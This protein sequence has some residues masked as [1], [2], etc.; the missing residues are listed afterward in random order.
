DPKTATDPLDFVPKGY[1]VA[2]TIEGDLNKDGQVDTVLLIKGTDPRNVV[3]DAN[4]QGVDRNRRGLIIAFKYA[5]HY[6]LALDN[7]TCF[8]SENEDGGVYMPP[9]LSVSIKKGILLLDYSHGRYGYWGYKFRYQHGHF[10]LIGYDNNESNGPIT[11]RI[12]SI[13]F[14]TKKMLVKENTNDAA[15][16]SG[17]EVFK[18]TWTRLSLPSPFLLKDITNFDSFYTDDISPLVQ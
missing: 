9:D 8:S 6:E 12:T 15:Q 18:D 16:E 4:N 17:Q 14:S 2:Q 7:P 1:V 11:Q 10:A 13:N 5:S 3:T